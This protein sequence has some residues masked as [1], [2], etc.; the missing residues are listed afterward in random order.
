MLEKKNKNQLGLFIDT[1]SALNKLFIIIVS[2]MLDVLF[3]QFIAMHYGISS[4]GKHRFD[5]AL[6]F[7]QTI[8][9]YRNKHGEVL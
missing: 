3:P 8:L 6:E 4:M 2:A 7:R 5:A 1:F 9:E